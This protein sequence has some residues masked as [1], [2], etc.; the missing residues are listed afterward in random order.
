MDN[1]PG[2]FRRLEPAARFER[3]T[4]FTLTSVIREP[5]LVP[6]SR[7]L[8]GNAGKTKPQYTFSEERAGSRHGPERNCDLGAMSTARRL[9]DR[10]LVLTGQTLRNL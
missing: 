7:R 1:E 2:T 6:C 4:Y 3:G 10:E 8:H 9:L 5:Q